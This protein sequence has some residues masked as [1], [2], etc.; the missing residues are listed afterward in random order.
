MNTETRRLIEKTQKL[1]INETNAGSF[2]T[3]KTDKYK[4][5]SSVYN[6][7]SHNLLFYGT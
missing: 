4:H 1:T 2:G 5:K 6:N 3:D 7:I